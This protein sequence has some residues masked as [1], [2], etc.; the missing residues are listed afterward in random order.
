M[1]STVLFFVS[2]V[3]YVISWPL[4]RTLVSDEPSTGSMSSSLHC[5]SFSTK[6]RAEAKHPHKEQK[7]KAKTYRQP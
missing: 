7:S 3:T 6:V 2:C 4:P 1:F 5:A